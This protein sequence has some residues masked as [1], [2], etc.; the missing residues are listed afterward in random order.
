M[1]AGKNIGFYDFEMG[2]IHESKTY[3]EYSFHYRN[4]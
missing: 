3:A 4:V 1:G 2:Q